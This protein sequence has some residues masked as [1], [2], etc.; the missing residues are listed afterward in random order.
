VLYYSA[1]SEWGP[2]VYKITPTNERFDGA[3]RFAVKASLLGI[4]LIS[5]Q[6]RCSHFSRGIERPVHKGCEEGSDRG[7]SDRGDLGQV[8]WSKIQVKDTGQVSVDQVDT[9]RCERDNSSVFVE[10][11]GSLFIKIYSIIQFVFYK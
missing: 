10:S 2:L 8:T 7:G 11:P 5:R 6:H 3:N 9:T 4:S 1:D